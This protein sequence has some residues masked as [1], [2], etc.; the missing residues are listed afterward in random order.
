MSEENQGGTASTG[1]RGEDLLMGHLTC[2]CIKSAN[3]AKANPQLPI[4][5]AA[6]SAALLSLLCIFCLTRVCKTV[7]LFIFYLCENISIFLV[8]AVHRWGFKLNNER[9]LAAGAVRHF[10]HRN[11]L[12]LTQTKRKKSI[13]VITFFFS[14]NRRKLNCSREKTR[15]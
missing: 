3:V 5:A 1:V 8:A 13:V 14:I 7:Y 10:L 9:K 12:L 6:I 15:S 11:S 4:A 2:R